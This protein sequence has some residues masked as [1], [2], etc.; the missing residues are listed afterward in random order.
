MK[1]LLDML[2][3]LLS[4]AHTAEQKL[5]D[6]FLKEIWEELKWH[7]RTTIVALIVL[8][9]LPVLLYIIGYIIGW[10][11]NEDTARAFLLTGALMASFLGTM[12]YA[13]ALYYG[14]ALKIFTVIVD[15][16][17]PAKPVSDDPE[18]ENIDP[19]SLRGQIEAKKKEVLPTYKL[20][21]FFNRLAGWMTW[22]GIA[23]LLLAVLNIWADF[24]VFVMLIV[25][26]LNAR[27]SMSAGWSPSLR[28]R[29]LAML[30]NTCILIYS[31][32]FLANKAL[33]N[34]LYNY[35]DSVVQ[36]RVQPLKRAVV[37]ET[38]RLKSQVQRDKRDT[39]LI[40]HFSGIRGD[41]E[42]RAQ[43]GCEGYSREDRESGEPFCSPA[44]RRAY[45]AL[46][47]KISRIENGTY[48]E[49][50]PVGRVV[51]IPEDELEEVSR[52][53]PT[54]ITDDE[55]AGDAVASTSDSPITITK[56]P[57]PPVLEEDTPVTP[58]RSTRRARSRSSGEGSGGSAGPVPNYRRIN[59][60]R[61]LAPLPLVR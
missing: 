1:A 53:Q 2:K 61:V 58:R 46:G 49:S 8:I 56:L 39:N 47:E 18:S 50:N 52:P 16:L 11:G 22:Y 36:A 20:E 37:L 55:P 29:R 7:Q 4:I 19:N 23:G 31:I 57:P 27:N 17:T 9:V 33:V 21:L 3:S 24:V 51:P 54:K 15:K 43:D 38:Q 34:T 10:A 45:A 48:W 35:G 41:L 14:W 12:F 40:K 13:R 32:G 28:T 6:G 44:D 59:W 26:L 30:F 60:N 5:K 42:K 25:G